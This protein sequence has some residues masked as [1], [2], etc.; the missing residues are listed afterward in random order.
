M[1]RIV[2]VLGIPRV[3]VSLRSARAYGAEINFAKGEL[4]VAPAEWGIGVPAC[5]DGTPHGMSSGNQTLIRFCASTAKALAK[6]VVG[7]FS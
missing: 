7:Y 4:G 6:R 3:K 2:T 5:P 1:C